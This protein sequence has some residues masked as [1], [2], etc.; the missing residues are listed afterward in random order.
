MS[1]E[2]FG[3]SVLI[4]GFGR[5]GKATLH[6]LKKN[7]PGIRFAIADEKNIDDAN[8]IETYS[9]N[10]YLNEINAF[11]TIILS[12]GVNTRLP[13]IKEALNQKKHITSATNIFFS[14]VKGKVIG[15]TGTKGKGST[16]TFLTSLLK[17]KFSDVRLVGNIGHPAL[18]ELDSS[19]EETIFVYELSSF[20]LET[21][22][23]SPDVAILLN[24]Y[25]EHLDFHKDLNSYILAKKN[26]TAFQNNSDVL[27]FN[28]EHESITEIVKSSNAKKVNYT[29][30]Y[31]ELEKNDFKLKG[32][33][34]RENITAAITCA[35]LFDV[36]DE[37]INKF[38]KNTEALKFRL[39]HIGNYKGIDFY[40][41]S[42][43]TNQGAAINA[44]E[45]LGGN[46]ETLIVGGY[47]R[48][49]DFRPIA[50]VISNSPVKNLIL[51]PD[52]GEEIFKLVSDSNRSIH[53]HKANSMEEA[54]TMAYKL[55]SANRSCLLA[56]GC[57]SFG[58]FR[59][60]VDRGE[61]FNFYVK[62]K[63]HI[64]Q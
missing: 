53:G 29:S 49:V 13:K 5:E 54:V 11:D 4:V 64:Q 19:T 45:A 38:I 27:V 60:Y 36:S 52:T 59:D 50:N 43:A 12:P 3:N 40:N 6:Y 25:P 2:I 1:N 9:G 22:K 10:G 42:Y 28:P 7:K 15:V 39:E 30:N 61:Q 34:N 56:P 37:S 47:N 55:T 18:E 23:Y 44:I 33:A 57:P 32:R 63:G 14:E 20:Q 58:I 17:T 62:D 21:L 16:C 26:I 8:D 41:D 24:I 48:G 51:F 46:L 35:R 31:Q